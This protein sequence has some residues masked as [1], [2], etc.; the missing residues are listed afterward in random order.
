MLDY[1]L[2]TAQGGDQP[3]VGSVQLAELLADQLVVFL[4]VDVCKHRCAQTVIR[5]ECK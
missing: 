4:A 1:S 2:G 5:V 3:A